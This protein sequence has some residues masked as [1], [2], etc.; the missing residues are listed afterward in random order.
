MYL[1]LDPWRDPA[2]DLAESTCFV[3]MSWQ[4]CRTSR[5]GLGPDF[6]P[7]QLL[8]RDIMCTLKGIV[9]LERH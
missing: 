8:K 4:T 1:A 2:R 5:T 9:A 6:G 3:G 7:V